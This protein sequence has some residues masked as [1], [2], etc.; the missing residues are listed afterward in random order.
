MGSVS[1]PS[2]RPSPAAGSRPR[3]ALEEQ[4]A[5]GL[6]IGRATGLLHHLAE[7]GVERALLAAAELLHGTGVLGDRLLDPGLER[8]RVDHLAQAAALHDRYGRVAGLERLLEH[9]LR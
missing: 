4:F 7:D 2:G 1:A 6:G 8:S 5:N 3:Q 9:L